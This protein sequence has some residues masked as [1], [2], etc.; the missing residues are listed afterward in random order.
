[1]INSV[2]NTVQGVLNKNNYGYI[3]PQDF[4]LYAKQAQMEIFEEYFTAYN[5]VINMEN[6]RVAGT[7]YA[8]IE[9]PLAE[10]LEFFLRSDFL[11]PILTPSGFTVNQWS[12][13]TLVTVGFDYYMINKL[14]CYTL[15]RATGQNTAT[16]PLNQLIDSGASFVNAGVVYGD[17]VVN[18]TT[19]ESATVMAVT[20]T[21]LDLSVN[22]FLAIGD[23]Y[24][25]Y[26]GT[27]AVDAEK[28]S[29]GKI[30]MLNNSMLTA[31]S[32][33]FPVYTLDNSSV[34]TAYPNSITG[35]GAVNATYFRYP[36]D[37]KWTYITLAS[38]EPL[39][40]QTQL[41]YQDFELPLEEEYKLAQKILQY[42]GMTI[43]ETE[44]V[45][46]TIGQEASRTANT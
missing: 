28:V 1:M 3:S 17:V 41:D 12:A 32:T 15:K 38:G 8:D 31:P 36:L 33:I 11:V 25:V 39:F 23:D 30:T 34:V 4:N 13:P 40:D 2:R 35:Y 44:V 14:L 24:A 45:Q 26:A 29:V 21:A 42:C 10:V 22:I 46:Y 9:Q 7:D 5:K 20:A 37:P 18:L 19:L 6:G 43:R 16:I 27:S